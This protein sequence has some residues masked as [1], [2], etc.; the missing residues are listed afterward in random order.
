M[1]N[2]TTKERVESRFY[3]LRIANLWSFTRDQNQ[4]HLIWVDGAG[5]QQPELIGV[6]IGEKDM[7]VV[8]LYMNMNDY[9]ITRIDIHMFEHGQ[10][11]VYTQTLSDHKLMDGVLMAGKSKLYRPSNGSSGQLRLIEERDL[12]SFRISQ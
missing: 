6:E 1:K 11:V 7:P 4:T 9:V 8:Q 12:L 2:V 3:N 5:V 10:K